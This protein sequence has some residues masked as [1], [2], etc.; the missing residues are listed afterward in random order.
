MQNSKRIL[1]ALDASPAS[2]R[3][4][5]YVADLVGGEQGFDVAL[6]HLE[7]PPRML[8]WG[9]SDDPEIEE[10]VSEER[11]RA[12]LEK[13]REAVEDG[14]ALLRRLQRPLIEHKVDV[15]ARLV[16]FDEPLDPKNIAH[17]VLKIAREK[18][19]RTVAVG[20]HCFFGLRRLFGIHV[21][22]ELVRAGKGLAVWVIE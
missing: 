17:D 6:V 2:R 13:E 15:T 5:N 4:V 3:A 12:Y 8:E 11:E 7:L 1:V 10:R 16:R 20:R 9:G 14:Q 22:E 19:Y 21:G 18:N